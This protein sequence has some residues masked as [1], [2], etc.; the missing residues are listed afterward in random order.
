MDKNIEFVEYS[1]IFLEKSWEWLN[2]K[3][4]KYLTCTPDFTKEQQKEWFLSLKDKKDYLIKGILCNNIPIG[5]VGLKNITKTDGE[6]WGYIGEKE[7]WNKGIGKELINYIFHYAYTLNL[8][9]IYL[10][11]IKDN[12]RAIKLYQKMNF[13]KFLEENELIYMKLYLKD[14]GEKN[15]NN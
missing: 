15:E 7:Y 10:K 13:E 12:T 3:K 11:V 5:V 14:F 6:Y 4:I 9:E 2:D 8:K 1:E